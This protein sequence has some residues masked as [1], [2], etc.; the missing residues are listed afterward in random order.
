MG[1]PTLTAALASGLTVRVPGK[2]GG[3]AAVRALRGGKLVA[4]GT[5]TVGAQGVAMVRLRFAAKARKALKRERSVK[6]TLVLDGG[7]AKLAV[8][9]RR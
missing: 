4:T 8:R 7:G 6:L 1:K 5:A 2:P 3:L 9:L